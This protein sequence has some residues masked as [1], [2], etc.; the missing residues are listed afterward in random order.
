MERIVVPTPFPVGPVN[1][2]LLRGDP[3]TLVDTGPSTPEALVALEAGLEA[4]GVAIEEIELLLLTHQHSDHVGLA[5]TIV[6]RSG[7][8]VAAHHL[9]VGFVRDVQAAMAAEEAWEDDLLRLH[10]T[11]S[12]RGGT[13]ARARSSTARWPTATCSRPVSYGCAWR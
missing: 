8:S 9:L 1:V 13:G 3:L 6:E 4:A 10:G 7:C 11:P 5:A 2:W 12:G